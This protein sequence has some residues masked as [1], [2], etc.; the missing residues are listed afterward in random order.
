MCV[1]KVC[2]KFAFSVMETHL[3]SHILNVL[4]LLCRMMFVVQ[5]FHTFLQTNKPMRIVCDIRTNVIAIMMLKVAAFGRH[6]LKRLYSEQRESRK[7]CQMKIKH[8][9]NQNEI[10]IKF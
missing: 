2:L 3:L 7:T 5:G 1:F 8:I 10:T 6:T 4:A 9:K